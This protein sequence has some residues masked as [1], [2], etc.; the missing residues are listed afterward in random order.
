MTWDSMT[1]APPMENKS[2]TRDGDGWH[3]RPQQSMKTGFKWIS[4][5]TKRMCWIGNKRPLSCVRP[6]YQLVYGVRRGYGMLDQSHRKIQFTWHGLLTHTMDC[7][8]VKVKNIPQTTNCLPIV[9][10]YTMVSWNKRVVPVTLNI[11]R[12]TKY[13]D[14]TGYIER[15]FR[16][17]ASSQKLNKTL[18]SEFKYR[19]RTTLLCIRPDVRNKCFH[20]REP[21]F[22]G[23]YPN[24]LVVM[25]WHHGRFL[26]SPQETYSRELL[27]W[28]QTEQFRSSERES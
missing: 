16:T 3:F 9:S 7:L 15:T 23:F 28:C 6:N 17:T 10:S 22:V 24:N 8:Y 4:W 18:I 14:K 1:T 12:N 5:K 13:N 26:H 27:V 2:A 21:V 11:K 19:K 25:E 20:L